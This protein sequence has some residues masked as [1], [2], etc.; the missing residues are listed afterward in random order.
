MMRSGFTLLEMI[1]ATALLVVLFSLVIPVYNSFQ[2]SSYL[3]TT[4]HDLVQSL[5]RAQTLAQAVST[6]DNWGVRIETN[7]IVVF[8]GSDYVS[9]NNAFDQVIDIASSVVRIS[10]WQ[11]IYFNKITGA[12]AVAGSVV[13]QGPDNNTS[14]ITVNSKGL[15]SY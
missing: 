11:E 15:I 10:G 2:T 4:T 12:P 8:K 5:R 1:L 3:Q 6:D 9:R 7:K 13:F 14:T